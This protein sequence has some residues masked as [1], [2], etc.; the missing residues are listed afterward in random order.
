MLKHQKL[1]KSSVG[2]GLKIFCFDLTHRISH[3]KKKSTV[4]DLGPPVTSETL[5]PVTLVKRVKAI[6]KSPGESNSYVVGFDNGP[7]LIT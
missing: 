4:T 5:L 1:H 3:K 6:R 7:P 2:G